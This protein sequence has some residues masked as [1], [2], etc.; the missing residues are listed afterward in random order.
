MR[1]GVNMLRSDDSFSPVE[2][3]RARK[4]VLQSLLGLSTVTQELAMRLT[5][6]SKFGLAPTYYNTLLQQV[7]AASPILLKSMVASELNP[8]NEVVVVKG[9]REQLEKAFK[10]AGIT[11]VKYVEPKLK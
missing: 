3:V 11:D 7:A 1:N 10:D 5:S 2:F 8:N 9:T 6:M 4:K